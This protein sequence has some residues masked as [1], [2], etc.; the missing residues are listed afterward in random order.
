MSEQNERL[1][2]ERNAQ[3]EKELASKTRE[4]EIEAAL[5]R[6]R[7]KAMAMRRSEDLDPAVAIVFEELDKLDLGVLRCGISILNKENRTGDIWVTSVTDQ[8]PAAQV[9]GQ[10]SFDIHPLLQG[11]FNGWLRQ[12]DFY[13]LLD[14]KDLTDYYNV[15]KAANFQLPES[16]MKSSRI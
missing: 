11:A 8:G 6:V 12:E 10:E 5:E 1:L 4:L 2:R 7:S 9:S 15:V 16:Q 14:G 3:L 13:Y